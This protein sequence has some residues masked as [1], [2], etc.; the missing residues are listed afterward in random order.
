MTPHF[1]RDV[2]GSSQVEHS[3]SSFLLPAVG[4][5]RAL[6]VVRILIPAGFEKGALTGESAMPKP[7]HLALCI[8]WGPW[9]HGD[10]GGQLSANGQVVLSSFW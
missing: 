4:P 3:Q 2:R 1:S 8:P 10:E 6:R 7:P 9:L 5:W